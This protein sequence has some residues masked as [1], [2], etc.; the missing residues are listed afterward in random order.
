MNSLIVDVSFRTRI[1]DCVI[2]FSHN[3]A[4]SLQDVK[5]VP[6]PA[7]FLPAKSINSAV[8]IIVLDLSKPATVL[9][10]CCE[11]IDNVNTALREQYSLL[12]SKGSKLPQQLKVGFSAS[13]FSRNIG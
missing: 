5:G 7:F 2:I 13:F 1:T 11:W 4:N 9:D 12:E 3:I 10:N 8:V 6:V